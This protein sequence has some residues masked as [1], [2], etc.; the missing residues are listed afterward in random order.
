MKTLILLITTLLLA[1]ATGARAQEYATKPAAPQ[2]SVLVYSE[3]DEALIYK[4][5]L[6]TQGKE[7]LIESLP[8]YG[9]AAIPVIVRQDENGSFTFK[10]HPNLLLPEFYTV[11]IEDTLTGEQFDLKNADSYSFV[12]S[13]MVPERFMLQMTKMKSNLTA[14][15]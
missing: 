10:K 12:V 8:E 9:K 2:K 6:H 4:N 15:R 5:E 14:M 13:K 7:I 1:S 3:E 11:I